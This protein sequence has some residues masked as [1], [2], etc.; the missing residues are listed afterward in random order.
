MGGRFGPPSEK[1]LAGTL[2][3]NVVSS[4][5]LHEWDLNSQL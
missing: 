2:S 5:P 4:T 3:Y 1:D